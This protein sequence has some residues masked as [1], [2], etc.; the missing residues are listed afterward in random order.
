MS[1]EFLKSFGLISNEEEIEKVQK[2]KELHDYKEALLWNFSH[3]KLP[4]EYH[5]HQSLNH[6]VQSDLE[7]DD[8][9]KNILKHMYGNNH[10]DLLLKKYSKIYSLDKK[11]LKDNQNFINNLEYGSN[12]ITEFVDDYLEFKSE[13]DFM[14]KYQYI[15]YEKLCFLNKNSYFLQCLGYYNFLSP[16]LSLLAPILGIIIPYFVLM[17]KGIVMPLRQYIALTSKIIYNGAIVNGIL[18]FHRNSLQTNAYTLISI[19]FYAMSFYNNIICCLNFYQNIN[20]LIKFIDRFNEFTDQSKSLFKN[21]KL[22]IKKYKSFDLFHKD[23]EYHE[24]NINTLKNKISTLCCNNE[25]ITKYGLMG[26][27]LESI[28]EIFYDENFHNSIMYVIY[29][30]EYMKTMNNVKTHIKNQAIHK[31]SYKSKKLTI[32][33]NYYLVQIDNSKTVKNDIDL[34]NNLIITGPNASGKTTMIKSCILNLFLCQSLGYGCFDKCHTQ[35]Y[36]YFH[37]YLNIPDT[38]GRDSLFQSEARR[39][40]DIYEFISAN[41]DKKHFCIFDEIYSGTNP[42]DAI[43]CANIYLKGMN[44]FKNCVDY[45]LT[46]HYIGLCEKFEKNDIVKNMKMNVLEKH[47]NSFLYTYKLVDGISKVNGGYQILV[48]LGY[49]QTLL[50][51]L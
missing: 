13:P 41:R 21:V 20:Y 3:F 42:N 11:F 23:L 50:D 14:N 32:K 37:S 16:A 48:E 46:T 30:D 39:C 4:I 28:Y 29:L 24:D 22:Q 43:L 44:K 33:N 8:S 25:K 34:S 27:L 6:N 38:S 47:S 36:D 31:C 2:A 12:T 1:E 7:I 35:I 18:N 49:P 15:Q 51:E 26:N 10:K 45:I 17:F 9:S 5:K 40:K 19:F